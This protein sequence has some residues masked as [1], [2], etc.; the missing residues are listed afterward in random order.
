LSFTTVSGS[1]QGL[2][3][4]TPDYK[5][6]IKNEAVMLKYSRDGIIF[7]LPV[8][9]VFA[10][11]VFQVWANQEKTQEELIHITWAEPYHH[12]H[13]IFF[14]SKKKGEWSQPIKLSNNDKINV[15]PAVTVDSEGVTWVVWAA[16]ETAGMD[17]YYQIF[18][19]NVWSRETRIE[20]TLRSNTSPTLLADNSG[21][22]RLAWSGNNG[23][24]DEIFISQWIDG[25]F[26]TPIQIT[27]NSVPD[28][29]PVL[30]MN[31]ADEMPR[32]EWFQPC[33][34]GNCRYYSRWTGTVWSKPLPV[35]A[36]A[37]EMVDNFSILEIEEKRNLI[38]GFVK[39]P[40][41]VSIY[42]DG[43]RIQSFP[44]RVYHNKNTQSAG[45]LC[46]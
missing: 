7:L 15:T 17:L 39:T 2:D 6:F 4:Q 28:I 38:P 33:D 27:S 23:G 11:H 35:S 25:M 16:V 18:Q 36:N 14:S 3:G 41:S 42:T 32:I 1:Q 44:L 8:W 22:L 30:H 29:L 24:N 10:G 12:E 9:F 45:Y 43:D 46:K 26:E 20:T 37:G 19:N 21:V 40:N 13:A 31:E 34:S 5:L